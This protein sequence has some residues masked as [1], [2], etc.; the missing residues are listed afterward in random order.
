MGIGRSVIAAIF[1]DPTMLVTRSP[2]VE[3]V[4]LKHKKDAKRRLGTV[5]EAR[6]AI[7]VIEEA[8]QCSIRE[9][10]D[11]HCRHH[12]LEYGDAIV[13]DPHDVHHIIPPEH[14]IGYAIEE[15]PDGYTLETLELLKVCYHMLR[16]RG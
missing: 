7:A 5:D 11:R 9:T 14:R 16:W 1:R 2:A 15:S 3:E 8:E 10:L 12:K 13:G 6:K 4:W